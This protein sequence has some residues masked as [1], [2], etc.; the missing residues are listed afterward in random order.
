MAI[1]I[2]GL[3]LLAVTFEPGKSS[4]I[5]IILGYVIA[6]PFMALFFSM[7][8]WGKSRKNRIHVSL[9]DFVSGSTRLSGISKVYIRAMR[10]VL[11]HL[12]VLNPCLIYPADTPEKLQYLTR[13]G[14][15][16][17]AFEL[18]LGVA[19]RLSISLND[20]DVDQI[21]ETV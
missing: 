9:S 3:I 16:P 10:H 19:R 21:T 7:D 17:F 14:R 15:P 1:F 11:G 20:D 6:V 12:Y 4:S 13:T 2:I 5:F 18:I 8:K